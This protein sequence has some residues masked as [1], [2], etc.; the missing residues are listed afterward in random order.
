MTLAPLSR[1]MARGKPRRADPAIVIR[2]LHALLEARFID[3]FLF[4]PPEARRSAA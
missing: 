4:P 3:R 2:Q 1:V